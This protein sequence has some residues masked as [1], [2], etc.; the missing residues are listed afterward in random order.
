[1]I[2]MK[3]IKILLPISAAFFLTGC[4]LDEKDDLPAYVTEVKARQK[5][6]IEPLPQ[7]KPY[8][9]FIY[10]AV[11]L[12]D[13]FM[14]SVV[15]HP[16]AFD[17]NNSGLDNGIRPD[18]YRQKEVLETY[19]LGELLLVGTL[20]QDDGIWGIIRAPDGV[21]HRVKKGNYIGQNNG[22]ILGITADEL[23]LKE[24]I[25]GKKFAH[26]E[27]ENSLSIRYE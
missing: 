21:V 13:P 5:V 10:A 9:S 4:I 6:D 8:E 25:P 24:I 3:N 26:E 22:K 2:N 18:E 19:P 20:E 15:Q 17:Q 1:M 12:R 14:K 23:K 27:R 7:V 11:E 16:N